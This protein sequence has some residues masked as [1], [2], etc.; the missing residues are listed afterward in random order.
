MK[1]AK[2]T[3]WAAIVACT[4]AIGLATAVGCKSDAG[5]TS[6]PDAKQM[7]MGAD[8]DIIQT[9]TGPNMEQ[10][11]TLVKAVQAAGLVDTLEGRGRSRCSPRRTTPSPPCPPARWTC[12]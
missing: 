4:A 10:V 7:M 9:A 11:T 8:K 5:G 3:R 2:T 1:S 6:S 12:C